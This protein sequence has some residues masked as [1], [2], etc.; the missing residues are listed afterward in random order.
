MTGP[1]YTFSPNTKIKSSEVNQNFLDAF[2]TATNY[3]PT[4]TT[5]SNPQPSYGNASQESYYVQLSA[6]A[7]LVNLNIQFGST[8]TFGTGQWFFAHPLGITTHQ[9]T[10]G[11]TR[12]VD[13]GVNEWEYTGVSDKNTGLFV[14]FTSFTGGAAV[15]SAAPFA[16]GNADIIRAQYF[17]IIP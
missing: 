6:K 11:L 9:P 4:W 10:H 12:Y 13:A 5:T 15:T 3:T 2:P 8:T 14:P 7:Y 17:L 16:W 1:T